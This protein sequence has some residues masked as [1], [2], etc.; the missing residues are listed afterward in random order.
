MKSLLF[1]C[2]FV[3]CS[4]AFGENT[5][6]APGN[7]GSDLITVDQQALLWYTV[8]FQNKDYGMA[9]GLDPAVMDRLKSIPS[10]K[11]S[12]QAYQVTNLL[13]NIGFWGGYCGF[14]VSSHWI[15]PSTI[16]PGD[17]LPESATRKAPLPALVGIGTSLI[18][19]TSSYV[20][21]WAAS[22]NLRAA[23]EAYDHE[24]LTQR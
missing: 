10:A 12:A 5:P 7:S 2:W 15:P 23:I 22:A 9:W 20:L 21:A 4:L 1:T 18:A 11:S 3:V 8:N 13:S 6:S 16:K 14:I 24:T 17:L 19:L